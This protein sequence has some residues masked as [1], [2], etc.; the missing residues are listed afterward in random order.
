MRVKDANDLLTPIWFGPLMVT[1]GLLFVAVII[2][3]S[4]RKD[5][6]EKGLTEIYSERCG[7]RFGAFSATFPFVRLTMYSD[8]LVISC[9][10]K[11]I[12]E[13]ERIKSCEAGSIFGFGIQIITTNND[14]YGQPIIWTFNKKKVLSILNDRIKNK[15]LRHEVKHST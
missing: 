12:I 10:T 5:I 2:I 4:I 8:F 6:R 3:L 15:H 1:I 14:K 7:G 13:Y 9:L 11:T